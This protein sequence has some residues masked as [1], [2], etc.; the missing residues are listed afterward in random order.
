MCEREHAAGGDVDRTKKTHEVT[1]VSREYLLS[2]ERGPQHHSVE[3][4]KKERI[5]G[6]KKHTPW[7]YAEWDAPFDA[8]SNTM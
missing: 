1:A 8:L 4:T 2:V 6:P 7:R 3:Q 5:H